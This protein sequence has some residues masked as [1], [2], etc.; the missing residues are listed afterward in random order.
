[1]HQ[2]LVIRSLTCSDKQTE[3]QQTNQL[4]SEATLYCLE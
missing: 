2:V 3:Q 4:E 1:M